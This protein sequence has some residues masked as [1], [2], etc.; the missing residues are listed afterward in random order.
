MK[1]KLKHGY[2]YSDDLDEEG[3]AI[4]VFKKNGIYDV[5]YHFEHEDFGDDSHTVYVIMNKD[6]ETMSVGCEVV[7]IIEE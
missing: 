7:E 2:R 5:V 4:I 1:A 6:G 3:F